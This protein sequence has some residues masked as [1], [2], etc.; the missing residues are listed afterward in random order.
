MVEK[1]EEGKP[2]PGGKPFLAR[3]FFVLLFAGVLLWVVG[4]VMRESDQASVMDGALHIARDGKL[5]GVAFY[6]YDRTFVSYWM[7]AGVF[8]GLGLEWA[9]ADTLVF[10]GNMLACALFLA[11]FAVAW[12]RCGPSDWCGWVVVLCCLLCPTLLFSIPLLSSNMLSAGWLFLL[13]AMMQGRGHLAGDLLAA[14]VAYLA[15]GARADAVLVM[16]LLSVLSCRE[17]SWASLFGDRRIWMVG[18]AS[19]LALATGWALSSIP[20]FNPP[21]IFEPHTFA[22]YF[23]FGLGGAL[24]LLVGLVAWKSAQLFKKPSLYGALTLLSLLAPLLYYSWL[25]Y[26]PRHLVTGALVLIYSTMFDRGRQWWSEM[27]KSRYGRAVVMG[28]AG[29]CAVLLFV[30]LSMDSMKGGKPTMGRATYYPTSDGHWPMGANLNFLLRLKHASSEPI[31]H[32]QRV[33]GA[34]K[35]IDP[36]EI[37]DTPV[38]VRSCGLESY[39]TLFLT[40]AAGVDAQARE[41]G[42]A[43]LVDGRSFFKQKA[44][45]KLAGAGGPIDWQTKKGQAVG[46]SPGDT[47]FLVGDSP[48]LEDNE[49]KIWQAASQVS[50]G[51]DYLLVPATRGQSMLHAP[52]KHR[53]MV[54]LPDGGDD[55]GKALSSIL[56]QAGIKDTRMDR[57][58]AT[59]IISFEAAGAKLPDVFAK[60]PEAAWLARS[61]LPAFMRRQRHGGR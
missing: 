22:A 23:V 27:M 41:A 7:L 57:V 28:S 17:S 4:P 3:L 54:I 53:W 18:I 51:D 55:E 21:A 20:P 45:S 33:W 26:T 35:D 32:N 50:E 40:M 16:P 52:G 34:W 37:A 30:G 10:A 8:K 58:Q 11:G 6:N 56:E 29:S 24:L 39:G 49:W 25:M 38:V 43:I 9:H 13:V 1:L 5:A 36:E 47:I 59:V 19:L 31:D 48:G 60:L 12:V 2:S 14:L 15:V 42:G 44:G 61:S 46:K